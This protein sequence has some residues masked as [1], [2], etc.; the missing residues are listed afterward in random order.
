MPTPHA[1]YTQHARVLLAL[2]ATGLGLF[3]QLFFAV[4]AVAQ[5]EPPSGL[6]YGWGS[7]D[8]G[9][10]GTERPYVSF[11]PLRLN[12]PNDIIAVSSGMWH[13]LVLRADGTVWSW[14]S[15]ESGALG[16]GR[17]CTELPEQIPGLENIVAVAAGERSSLALDRDG[18][19]YAWGCLNE[20]LSWDG[21]DV[22]YH[23]P[24]LVEG[25]NNVIAIAVNG[26]FALAVCEDGSCWGWGDN[27]CDQLG[28]D[29]A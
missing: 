25:L 8:W 15:N 20:F 13:T 17:G 27:A 28:P 6:V 14:G 18:K 10:L 5:T 24:A 26:W 22:D 21:L 29:A 19:V 3:L 12:A 7:N 23:R 11:L 9:E 2:A 1:R 4:C 16:R